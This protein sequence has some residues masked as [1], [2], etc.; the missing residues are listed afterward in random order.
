[1][2][3]WDFAVKNVMTQFL[4][5]LYAQVVDFLG[6]FL[7][8]MNMMGTE[9]FDLDWIK[10]IILFFQMLG[11]SLFTVGLSVSVFDTV[12]EMQNGRGSIRDTA[13]NLIKGFMA[14]GLFTV[15]PVELYK[16]SVTLQS[17]LISSFTSLGSSFD[18]ISTM[19]L[20][21]IENII[22]PGSSSAILLVVVI[23]IGYAI[24]KVFF[25]NLKRGG[26]LLTMIAVG[27][28][29]MFSVPRGYMDGFI[30]WC[31]QVIALCVTAF[32]Q[33][34]VLVAGLITFNENMI[35]GIGLMLSATEVPRIANH[36][37]LDT[38]TKT[39]FM[40][41]AYTA[42]SAINLVKTAVAVVK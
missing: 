10:G 30:S 13:I 1:M 40:S 17:G 25:A 27:S 15:V 35:L 19:G 11:W 42:Q 34:I 29:Y 39:N 23:L 37:G 28:L 31:K 5:W 12:I 4:D 20:A 21:L 24:I 16:T 8:M 33:T 38:S 6:Q 41:A 36:F 32:L 22:M 18:G 2:F 14:A 26:I 9:L 3:L 7:A